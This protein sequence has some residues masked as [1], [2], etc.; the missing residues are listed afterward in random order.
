[1]AWLQLND[2]DPL[3]WTVFYLLVSLVPVL[4]A[5]DKRSPLLH[6]LVL[7]YALACLLIA[8]PGFVDYLAS[9]D[10]G[11]ISGGMRADKPYVESAREFL[12]TMIALVPLFI[13][14]RWHSLPIGVGTPLN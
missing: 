7:G 3:F 14:W 10:Y 2:P 12:G 5:V 8:L 9:N 11:A 1:M 4:R 13:Y 6:R